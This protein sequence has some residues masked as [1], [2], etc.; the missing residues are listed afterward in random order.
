M[1]LREI[2]PTETSFIQ[3][4]KGKIAA[5]TGDFADARGSVRGG[6]AGAFT[7][8]GLVGEIAYIVVLKGDAD[9]DD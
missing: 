6:G 9:E 2:L 7:D 1:R 8:Q 4:G 3:S 5:G